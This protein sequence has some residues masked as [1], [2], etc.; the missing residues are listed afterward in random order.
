MLDYKNIIIKRFALSMSGTEI[1]KEINASKS[2]VNDFLKAFRECGKLQYPLPVGITNYAIYELVYG[3]APGNNI[4]NPNIVYPDYH[5]V[6]DKMQSRKN[7][8][9]VYLWNCYKKKCE[10]DGLRYYQ[11]RQFCENYNEWCEENTETLHFTANIA[12]KME[13]DFAGETFRLVDPLTGELDTIVVFVAVLPYSQYIYA[14]GM[15][16]T[17]EPEWIKV[18]NNALDF[19]GGV[20]AVVV[21][22]NC[23]QAVIVNQDWIAPELN[24]DYAEWAEHNH[25]VIM[26]AKVRKPKFKSSVENAVGILEKGLFHD[27]EEMTY[28][29]LD[30]FN[31]D[32]WERIDKLNKEPFKK[33]EHNRLYYW[34]E[35]KAELMPLPSMHYEYMERRVAKVSSD[36]HVRFDNSYYSVDKAFLH[37]EISIRATESVVRIYSKQGEFIYEWPRAT[38][39]GQW[40]TNPDHL[41]SNYQGYGQWSASWFINKASLIGPNTV[42]VIKNILGSRKYEVQT[43]RMCRGVLGFKERYGAKILEECCGQA[44]KSGKMTYT[45]VKNTVTAIA[46]ENGDTVRNSDKVKRGGYVMDSE[47]NSIENLLSRSRKLADTEGKDGDGTC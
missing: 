35:E 40:S 17:K 44:V 42:D 16:S 18:N 26:P 19:F 45:F 23:K 10:Q 31:R 2:G 5:E 21:C 30:D 22:D 11:Y 3:K 32:L 20:P 43:Y 14:E 7:M 25:T 4:H 36:Y 29:S 47:A 8:T 9:L 27:L 12:E 1:A 28:F 24:K 38:R 41:P 15:L 33:K 37:K 39:K 13:V 6:A 46:M 34:E